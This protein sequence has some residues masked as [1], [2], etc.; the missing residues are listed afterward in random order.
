[1]PQ[2]DLLLPWRRVIENATLGLEVAGVRRVAASQQVAPLLEAFGL[3]GFERSYPFELSGGMR[4]RAALL[5]TVVQVRS[6][7]CWTSPSA[8]STRSRVLMY[9]SG[10]ARLGTVRLDG[11]ASDS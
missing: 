2:K 10:W 1:M 9:R 6:I 3:A 7:L 8:R 11:R 4:Q 5:H